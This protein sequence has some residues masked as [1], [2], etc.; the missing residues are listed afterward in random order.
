MNFMSTK[1]CLWPDGPS[2]RCLKS[3][4]CVPIKVTHFIGIVAVSFAISLV[5]TLTF[6][7]P[8]MHL[9]KLLVGGKSLHCVSSPQSR[10]FV[11][12][13][14]YVPPVFGRTLQLLCSQTGN[15]HFLTENKTSQLRG[16]NTLHWSVDLN[17]NG[18]WLHLFQS[19][20]E[21]AKN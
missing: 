20:C 7:A 8:F 10:C 19:L 3:Y 18:N 14:W 6:E 13:L 16:R 15:R 12:H 11:D 2:C 17:L 21:A 1:W 4:N 9:Q 5:F